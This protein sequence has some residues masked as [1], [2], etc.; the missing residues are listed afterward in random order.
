MKKRS[1][2]FGYTYHDGQLV[3]DSEKADIVK[4][5]FNQYLEN[6]SLLE[7]SSMLNKLHIEYQP[8]VVNWN[9][10]RIK[11]IIEE[12][13]Y[14]GDDLYPQIIDT[15]TLTKANMIKAAKNNQQMIDRSSDIYSISTLVVCP[16]CGGKM[17]RFVDRRTEIQQ[18]WKCQSQSCKMKIIKDDTLFIK[19]I[20]IVLNRLIEH[21]EHI[22]EIETGEREKLELSRIETEI[23]RI[24]DYGQ[25]DKEEMKSRLFE[26]ASMKYSCLDDV[27]YTSRRLISIFTIQ[28]PVNRFSYELFRETVETISFNE[29]HEAVIKLINGQLVGKESF[30]GTACKTSQSDRSDKKC[31]EYNKGKIQT[32]EGSSLLPGVDTAGR[33]A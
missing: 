21:P 15:D 27:K 7:I 30:C 9:K 4:E 17:K 16:R 2:L 19:E 1:V 26:W 5:I 12:K 22:K 28:K 29:D 8:G 10:A 32:E 18:R 25:A 23:N 20:T 33:T 3:T 24:L 13:R 6:K 14:G 31:R 11:R